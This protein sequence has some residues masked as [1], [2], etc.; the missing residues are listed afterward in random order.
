MA[1]DTEEKDG[2]RYYYLDD[3]KTKVPSVTTI[4][5]S[6][7][8]WNKY[9][10]MAWAHKLGKEGKSFKDEQKSA[11]SIG[12]IA[13]KMA[14][15]NIKGL[16]HIVCPADGDAELYEKANV[17]FNQ[18][19]QWKKMTRL[20]IIESEVRV[21]HDD[22]GIGFGG[23]IDAIAKDDEGYLHIIDFKT[24]NNCYPEYII[25]VAAYIRGYAFKMNKGFDDFKGV[26]LLRFGKDAPTFAHH[27]ADADHIG[28]AWEAFVALHKLFT[29]KKV[30]SK[31][32]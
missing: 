30:V 11:M 20:N 1:K 5:G 2:E 17:A 32:L 7:L 14:E 18:F 19:L 26:H 25:Q 13:H 6:G 27:Y 15:H 16:D 3:G 21:V 23:T 31:M 4:I 24:S 9:V 10:L 22:E 29:V 12:T 28:P 8:G